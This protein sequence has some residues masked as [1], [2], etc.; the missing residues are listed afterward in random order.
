MDASVSIPIA[1]G[2]LCQQCGYDL[3]GL[4]GEHCP[5]CGRSLAGVRALTSQL[6]WQHRD[7][8]GIGRAYWRTVNLA[9]FRQAR[10]CD[11]LARPVDYAAAQ[12]FRLVT[13]AHVLAPLAAALTITLVLYGDDFRRAWSLQGSSWLVLGAV[14]IWMH[15]ALFLLAA[16]GLPSYFFHP[17][18]CTIDQQNRALALSYYAG[19]PLAVSAAPMAMLLSTSP[20]SAVTVI[21][22]FVRLLGILLGLALFA[23]WW[24]DLLHL[25]RRL[26]RRQPRRAWLLAAC[27]P[28][29]WLLAAIACFLVLPL[30]WVYIAVAAGGAI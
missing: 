28:M 2:I 10:F 13:I 24:L 21:E 19:G 17:R 11:E 29:F 8:I 25:M 7:E 5:E 12:S 4:T 22:L 3:R 15:A 1:A 18:G 23:V 9:M 30:I 16:T 6:P 27:L 20:F 14:V 26:I